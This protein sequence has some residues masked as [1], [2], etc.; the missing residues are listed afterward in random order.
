M[1]FVDSGGYIILTYTLAIIPWVFINVF[2]HINKK[3]E[4]TSVSHDNMTINIDND[5]EPDPFK[6]TIFQDSIKK[7]K[8]KFFR[9][10]YKT[11]THIVYFIGNLVSLIYYTFINFQKGNYHESMAT[12]AI[13]IAAFFPVNRVIRQMYIIRSESSLGHE[14]TYLCKKAEGN[15][16]EKE[17]EKEKFKWYSNNNNSFFDN[18][19]PGEGVTDISIFRWVK[20]FFS[21]KLSKYQLYK[22]MKNTK[23]NEIINEEIEEENDENQNDEE[24]NNYKQNYKKYFSTIDHSYKIA[25]YKMRLVTSRAGYEMNRDMRIKGADNGIIKMVWL[26]D[27][28]IYNKDIFTYIFQIGIFMHCLTQII[29]NHDKTLTQEQVDNMEWLEWLKGKED[30]KNNMEWL[31]WIKG[32]EDK[33]N[34]YEKQSEH[35]KGDNGNFK[36]DEGHLRDCMLLQCNPYITAF[37][38]EDYQEMYTRLPPYRASNGQYKWENIM[39]II[40]STIELS[41]LTENMIKRESKYNFFSYIKNQIK[42]MLYINYKRN[43]EKIRRIR[44]KIDR[45]IIQEGKIYNSSKLFLEENKTNINNLKD[46]YISTKEERKEEEKDEFKKDELIDYENKLSYLRIESYKIDNLFIEIKLHSKNNEDDRREYIEYFKKLNLKSL[47]EEYEFEFETKEYDGITELL[48]KN[49][50]NNNKKIETKIEKLSSMTKLL[51]KANKDKIEKLNKINNILSKVNYNYKERLDNYDHEKNEKI[52]K[53]LES[54]LKFLSELDENN[55]SQE[56]IMNKMKDDCYTIAYNMS[57]LASHRSDLHEPE[58]LKGEIYSKSKNLGKYC[59][60]LHEKMRNMNDK[61]YF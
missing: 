49:I 52:K 40:S 60:K 57:Y 5:N 8:N 47:S 29:N 1:S 18:D 61:I 36:Q 48:E 12:I 15:E 23:E 56:F 51:S 2:D 4:P 27:N 11:W 6:N 17:K 31:E 20:E 30:K 58:K 10:Y 7:L 33:K 34:L 26:Y 22:L 19:N 16:E 39:Y 25:I 14:L 54:K 46:Y 13:I 43:F 50:Y 21:Y 44:S 9:V 53:E 41:I 38:P 35:L 59:I 55:D 45:F 32:K 37:P 24:K 3:W 28:M 42:C